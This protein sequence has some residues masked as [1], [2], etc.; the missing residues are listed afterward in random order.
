MYD[1]GVESGMQE[2]APGAKIIQIGIPNDVLVLRSFFND[3]FGQESVDPISLLQQEVG[4]DAIR[5]TDD[6]ID[7]LI[8]SHTL[9]T[10]IEA[11]GKDVIVTVGLPGVGSELNY[12]SD[13]EGC[14]KIIVSPELLMACTKRIQDATHGDLTDEQS[15]RIG[16][17]MG[18]GFAR[19]M[20]L[21]DAISPHNLLNSGKPIDAVK[22]KLIMQL[23]TTDIDSYF[24]Y[25][26]TQVLTRQQVS[27]YVDRILPLRFAAAMTYAMLPESL[28]KVGLEPTAAEH[29]VRSFFETQ[30]MRV[31]SVEGAGVEPPLIERALATPLPFEEFATFS[32][33]AALIRKDLTPVR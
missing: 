31:A 18:I 25:Q 8:N 11:F 28:E 9:D 17:G 14:H 5:R 16:F 7:S 15:M 26:G 4:P 12:C 33:Y 30:I 29:V 13:P 19:A 27:L 10:L 2:F 1:K 22:I 23:M 6:Y 20:V 21:F 32:K 3:Q 24:D